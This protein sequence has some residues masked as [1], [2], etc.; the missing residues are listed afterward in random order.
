MG[1]QRA[2]LDCLAEINVAAWFEENNTLTVL[3]SDYQRVRLEDFY[4]KANEEIIGKHWERKTDE[5]KMFQNPFET[6][7]HLV[8]DYQ[9]DG[10]QSYK[11]AQFE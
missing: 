1:M 9:I 10:E 8:D 6:Q 7:F 3:T 4:E 5:E 11:Y 2:V